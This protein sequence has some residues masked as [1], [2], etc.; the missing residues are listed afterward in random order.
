MIKLA[1]NGPKRGAPRVLLA[2]GAGTGMDSPFMREVAAG[3]AA[4]DIGVARFEFPYMQRRRKSGKRSPPDRAPVLLESFR[5]AVAQLGA[6][7]EL[8]IGGKSMGGRMASMLADELGV[9]GVLCLGYPF[10]PPG[11]PDKTRT[12]HLAGLKTRCLIVQGTRD[13]FGTRED[14]AGYVLSRRIRVVYIDDA[15]HDLA[16]LGGKVVREAARER[17]LEAAAR[18]VL[19]GR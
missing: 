2:H 12:E 15:G 19:K 8:V 10:H 11:Q 17:W 6:A 7:D 4:H 3:L 5:S 14:I 16:P 18:F 9:A 13:P 1:W